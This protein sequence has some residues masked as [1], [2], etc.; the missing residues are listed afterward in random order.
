MSRVREW[1]EAGLRPI[2]TAG[3]GTAQ[4]ATTLHFLSVGPVAACNMVR[5]AL[6][7]LRNC[8]LTIATDYRELW[9]I[10]AQDN[11]DVA[12]LHQTLLPFELEEASRLIRRRWPGAKTLVI[13]SGTEFLEDALY[14]DRLLPDSV[15]ESLLCAIEKV[16]GRRQG[17][18]SGM[19][20]M[21]RLGTAEN[22]D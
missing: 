5:D 20:E 17:R 12:I 18:K 15:P 6:L 22:A 14:D 1:K 10:P 9:V 19:A 13:R 8:R 7:Q 2:H 3:S 11:I 21:P 4:P 16:T